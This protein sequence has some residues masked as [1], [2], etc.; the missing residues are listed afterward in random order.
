MGIKERSAERRKRLV[1]H[2]ARNHEEAEHWDLEFWQK[3]GPQARLA[4]LEAILE[5]I[6]RIKRGR[7]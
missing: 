1:G 6:R 4:A 7:R 2:I 3:Q 5:D